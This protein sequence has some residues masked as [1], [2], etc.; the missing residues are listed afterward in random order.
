MEEL[1][2]EA[3]LF[4]QPAGIDAILVAGI[5]NWDTVCFGFVSFSSGKIDIFEK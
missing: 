3:G 5:I 1:A 2:F 4:N